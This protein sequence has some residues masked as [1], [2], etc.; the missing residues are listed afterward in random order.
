MNRVHKTK[1]PLKGNDLLLVVDRL[2]S[3]YYEVETVSES[4]AQ[5][6][7]RGHH[8]T[9]VTNSLFINTRL[10]D[11]VEVV[12]QLICINKPKIYYVSDPLIAEATRTQLLSI[13]KRDTKPRY[14]RR[15]TISPTQ[16]KY[17]SIDTI[18][19]ISTGRLVFNFEVKDYIV[20]IEIEGISKYLHDNLNGTSSNYKLIQKYIRTALDSQ[21]IKI[22]C[23]CPDFRYRFA[24]TATVG[25]FKYGSPENRPSN[26]TNPQKRGSSCKHLLYLLNNKQW[27]RK[28]VSLIN[29]LI[30]LNPDILN[31]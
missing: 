23:T 30:K 19:F 2:V 18:L 7:I 15:M 9:K 5:S 28:Y 25:K 29:L 13:S 31:K 4:V 12:D 17:N 11:D 27:V 20:N 6:F 22:N 14:I 3:D 26:I 16:V 8:L 1:L 24:Y 21:D 10:V